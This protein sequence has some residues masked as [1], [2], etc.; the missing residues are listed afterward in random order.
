MLEDLHNIGPDYDPTLMAW[1]ENFDRTYPRA[2]RTA[3]TALLPDVEV[4]P[5]RGRRR[6]ALARRPALP[7]RADEDRPRAARLPRELS[8]ATARRY[9]TT[10]AGVR[11]AEPMNSIEPASAS[12]YGV[13]MYSMPCRAHHARVIAAARR[14]FACGS[15]GNRWCS[16]W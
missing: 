13:E 15:F 4:L 2:Q 3:T 9:A 14:R 12:R 11:H 6:V 8:R 7:A 16:I 10:I 1:W 5:A